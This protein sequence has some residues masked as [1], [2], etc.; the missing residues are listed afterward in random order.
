[1]NFVAPEALIFWTTIFFLIFFFLL[2]KFAWKPILNSVK[3]R[4][5]SI[6]NALEQAEQARKEMQNLTADNERILK[7]AR[8]EREELLKDARSMRE[9]MIETAKNEAQTEAHKLLEKAKESIETEKLAAIT[10]LKKQVAELSIG[11][12]EKLMKDQLASKD[13]QVKLIDNM[14]KD[15]KLN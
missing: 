5:A 1:M 10:D 3:E 14:L 12:A 8:N 4:E 6:N 11:I 15:I 13:A 9:N 2:R 7:E